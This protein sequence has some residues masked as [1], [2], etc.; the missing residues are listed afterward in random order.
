MSVW[1]VVNAGRA[2]ISGAELALRYRP[3]A[4]WTFNAAYTYIDAKL[5]ED[6]PMDRETGCYTRRLFYLREEDSQLNMNQ[7]PK[8]SVDPRSVLPSVLGEPPREEEVERGYPWYVRRAGLGLSSARQP[9][10]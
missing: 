6:A 9:A 2:E 7:F 1:V 5:T 10:G 4:Q 3:T 8:D